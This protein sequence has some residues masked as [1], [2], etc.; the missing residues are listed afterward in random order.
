MIKS[1]AVAYRKSGMSHEEFCRYWKDIHA[2]LAARVIPGMR[3]YVQNHVIT[4]PGQQSDADGIV[5]MWWNDLEAFRKFNT[6]VKTDAGKALR[7]DSDKFNDMTK[8]KLWLVEEHII[9]A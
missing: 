1:I 7:D 4:V 6:W 8:S 5:E 2:P 9:K 3:K